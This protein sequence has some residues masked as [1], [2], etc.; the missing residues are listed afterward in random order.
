MSVLSYRPCAPM[1][2]ALSL[3]A[4]MVGPDYHRPAVPVP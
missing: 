2:L 3:G 4:C 1:V